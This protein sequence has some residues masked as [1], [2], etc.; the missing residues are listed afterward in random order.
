[1]EV[2]IM[3]ANAV[4]AQIREEGTFETCLGGPEEAVYVHNN[5]IWVI[6]E[7][8]GEVYSVWNPTE[9]VLLYA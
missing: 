4:A 8:A 6:R 1:M 5:D 9:D 7:K 3:S 2:S